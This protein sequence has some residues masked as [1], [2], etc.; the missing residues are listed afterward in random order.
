M[1][2]EVKQCGQ[3]QNVVIQHHGKKIKVI[4]IDANGVKTKQISSKKDIKKHL[5][6]KRNRI[7]LSTFIVLLIFCSIGVNFLTRDSLENRLYDKYYRPINTNQSKYNIEYSAFEEAKR[8]YSAGEQNTAWLLIKNRN[9]NANSEIEIL[10]YQALILI[11][12]ERYNDAI[13]KLDSLLDISQTNHIELIAQWYKGLCL[14][15]TKQIDK[16][17]KCFE[18][19][20]MEG[21]R[22]YN[23]S[24][25]ILKKLKEKNN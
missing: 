22:Y 5:A 16:A 10:T 4:S 8:K 21:S 25:K 3:N 11:E 12:L 15:K 24:I 19:T 6:N 9:Q 13:T 18:C 1:K 2:L 23:Q 7:Y 14:L 20:S 17:T